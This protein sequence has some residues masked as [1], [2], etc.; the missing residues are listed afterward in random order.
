MKAPYGVLIPGKLEDDPNTPEDEHL[1]R[2]YPNFT[3][4]GNSDP[5]KDVYPNETDT[6]DDNDGKPDTSDLEPLDPNIPVASKN[7]REPSPEPEPSPLSETSGDV[8]YTSDRESPLYSDFINELISNGTKFTAENIVYIGKDQTGKVV[9]LE[10][11]NDKAG[12]QHIVKNHK[13]EFED[14]GIL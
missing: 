1:P 2:K 6:N 8:G 9:W 3:H 7:P 4:P 14:N 13:S 10:V 5:D 12:L 11:G